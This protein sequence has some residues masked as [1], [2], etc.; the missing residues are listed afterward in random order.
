MATNGSG[1]EQT[2]ISLVALIG[3]V[4]DKRLR[5]VIRLIESEELNS[6][7]ALAIEV[8]L[9]SSHLQHLFKQQAGV[10]ITK[11]L[12]RQ[13]LRKAAHH[14]EVSDMSIREVACAVGYEHASSFIRAF[15]RYFA[16][17]PRAYRYRSVRPNLKN[18]PFRLTLDRQDIDTLE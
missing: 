3:T 14:L 8:N 1:G 4:Q 7:Q 13:R 11:L 6:V 12:T 16:Q 18:K 2:V 10:C 17:T 9:S 5:K 15:Q